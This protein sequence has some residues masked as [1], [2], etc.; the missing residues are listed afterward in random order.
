M[1]TV[2]KT[3]SPFAWFGLDCNMNIPRAQINRHMDAGSC[4][5]AK[6]GGIGV[7]RRGVYLENQ[8]VGNSDPVIFTERRL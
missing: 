8:P 7:F 3:K 5:N 2:Y 1:K 6:D 4:F